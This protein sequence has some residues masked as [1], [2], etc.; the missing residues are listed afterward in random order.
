MR[1]HFN[2]CR[3]YCLNDEGGLVIAHWPDDVYRP[4]IPIPYAGETQNGYEWAACIHMIQAGLITG[5]MTCVEAI[6]SRYDG[7]KR[8]P[9]NEFECGNNY[10]RSMATYSLLNTFSGFEFDVPRSMIGFSPIRKVKGK[11]RCFWSLDSGWG[12]FEQSA[13]TAELRLLSGSLKLKTLRLGKL[14]KATVR[15]VRL[16]GKVVPFEFDGVAIRLKRMVRIKEGQTLRV[17]L[18]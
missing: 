14:G 7:R 9:W 18:G 8:N 1:E 16:A 12:E 3:L 4:Y 6:R 2:A 15:S 11:F 5:G 13:N 10:A 17:K